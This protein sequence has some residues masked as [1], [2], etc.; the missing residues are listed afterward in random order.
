MEASTEMAAI[1]GSITDIARQ[2]ALQVV[3]EGIENGAQLALLQSVHCHYV[4]GYVF[5]RPLDAARATALLERGT[6]LA[7][8][9]D[10]SPAMA[11]SGRAAHRANSVPRLVAQPSI[12]RGGSPAVGGGGHGGGSRPPRRRRR[13]L[14]P[15]RRLGACGGEPRLL[16]HER[17]PLNSGAAAEP[18]ALAPSTRARRAPGHGR[19][20]DSKGHLGPR[21]QRPSAHCDRQS[22][23]SQWRRRGTLAPG[24][25]A[26]NPVATAR[27]V[28]QHR[29]AVAGVLKASAQGL[30][31][32]PE[33][34]ASKDAF[35]FA[36]RDFV[37]DLDGETLVLKTSN[38]TFRFQPVNTNGKRDSGELS[39]LLA[40]LKAHAKR[41][42]VNAR[43]ALE[44][45]QGE[46][47]M[48]LGWTDD[49]REAEQARLMAIP[50]LGRVPDIAR[51]VLVCIGTMHAGFTLCS[52]AAD[53][54]GRT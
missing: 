9:V 35:T 31:F 6:S 12:R 17:A 30:A 2:L 28:H 36:Y 7:P 1:L 43:R 29:W 16:D 42:A 18:A 48:S 26:A 39:A 8:A 11:S 27:V 38:R 23:R 13:L 34:P 32:E 51:V 47:V 37:H 5:S 10:I 45:N 4:Q 14:R 20:V 54:F 25:R 21:G 44:A 40:T 41:R 15:R 46:A 49:G 52:S 24:A 33:G 19:D 3:V 53:R 22:R 50:G